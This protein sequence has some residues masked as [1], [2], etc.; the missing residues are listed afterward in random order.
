[1]STSPHV[2]LSEDVLGKA[3][4]QFYEEASLIPMGVAVQAVE[5]VAAKMAYALAK[6]VRHFRV[7]YSSAPEKGKNKALTALKKR[8]HEAQ[9]P[10]S[11]GTL[12]RK[13]TEE[14]L[15]QLSGTTSGVDWKLL[16]EKIRQKGSQHEAA[17]ASAQD[18]CNRPVATPA[19]AA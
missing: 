7:L 18:A 8:L 13:A 11:A 2:R 14:D 15:D 3:I 9:V 16:A 12:K 6:L 1:M 10:A 5:G 17:S 19:R 4:V